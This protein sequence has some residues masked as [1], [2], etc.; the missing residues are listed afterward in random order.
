MQDQWKGE[1]CFEEME[2]IIKFVKSFSIKGSR[3]WVSGWRG[4][5]GQRKPFSQGLSTHP[6]PLPMP[7]GG[8]KG[9]ER[10]RP[11]KYPKIMNKQNPGPPAVWSKCF[12][13]ADLCPRNWAASVLLSLGQAGQRKQIIPVLSLE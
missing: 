5:W 4:G 11:T 2:R 1:Q 12:G 7:R 9:N 10:E 6:H 13:P 8:S 3:L